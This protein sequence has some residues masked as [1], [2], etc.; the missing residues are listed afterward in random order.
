MLTSKTISTLSGL[1]AEIILFLL[2][3]SKI[4]FT[5]TTIP[6]NQYIF[7]K[8]Y[9]NNFFL[10][11]KKKKKTNQK[12]NAKI[13]S[14]AK[15]LIKSFNGVSISWVN[16]ICTSDQNLKCKPLTKTIENWQIPKISVYCLMQLIKINSF[17]IFFEKISNQKKKLK[18]KKDK[19][20]IL[21]L[22]ILLVSYYG[23][24]QFS[25]VFDTLKE[26]KKVSS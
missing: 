22:K 18:K 23:M 19:R 21:I 14:N 4:K 26:C 17:L 2:N 15:V 12:R 8:C 24:R 3:T 25:V 7:L 11:I 5:L 16:K 9:C 20:I 6:I 1:D 13:K 10:P